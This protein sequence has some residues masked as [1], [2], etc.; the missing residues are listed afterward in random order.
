MHLAELP[1]DVLLIPPVHSVVTMDFAL[2]VPVIVRLTRSLAVL[3]A[4]HTNADKL[5]NVLLLNLS[6]LFFLNQTAVLQALQSSVLTANAKRQPP[7]AQWVHLELVH[8]LHQSCV[9]T[10]PAVLFAIVLQQHVLI[11]GARMALAVPV[12]QIAVHTMV[13]MEH[14]LTVAWMGLVLHSQQQLTVRPHAQFQ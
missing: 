4:T 12:M 7:T 2:Q 11:L 14:I 1:E 8:N 9:L 6:A 13:A 10:V 5:E 3:V